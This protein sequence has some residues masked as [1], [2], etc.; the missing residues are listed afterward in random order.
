MIDVLDPSAVVIGG[1]VSNLDLL[2]DEGARR[3]AH[4]WREW[5]ITNR[6]A[7]ESTGFLLVPD[8]ATEPPQ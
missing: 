8:A 4:Y 1:G 5:E 7:A 3:V 2:Y 6:P